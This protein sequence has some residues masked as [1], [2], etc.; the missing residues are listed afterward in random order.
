MKKSVLKLNLG[1]GPVIIDGWINVDYAI[2]ARLNK[3]LLFRK[4][5]KKIG[6]FACRMGKAGRTFKGMKQKLKGN[7]ILGEID[8]S[9][10]LKKGKEK[11]AELVSKWAKDIVSKIS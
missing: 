7:E 2:G 11:D 5:N 4:L 3:F 8:I 6:L 1:C 9:E 10:P